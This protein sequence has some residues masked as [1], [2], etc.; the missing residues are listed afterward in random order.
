MDPPIP[1]P[2]AFPAPVELAVPPPLVVNPVV[3]ATEWPP[4]PHAPTATIA[5]TY[6]RRI[7]K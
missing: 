3:V 5:V 6:A 7:Q 2:F 4:L 1:V